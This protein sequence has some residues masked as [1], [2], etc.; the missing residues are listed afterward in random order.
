MRFDH[1]EKSVR[2]F[3]IV[4]ASDPEPEAVID[5]D[6]HPA[7][8]FGKWFLGLESQSEQILTEKFSRSFAP[9]IGVDLLL[10]S[11]VWRKP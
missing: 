9:Q 6:N 7:P 8:V 10:L 2:I 3:L 5:D 11:F 1:A 4:A